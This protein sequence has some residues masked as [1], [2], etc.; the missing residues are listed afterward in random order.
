MAH[1][2][3]TKAVDK[4][5]LPNQP[6]K[7]NFTLRSAYETVMK[8]YQCDHMHVLE[9]CKQWKQGERLK[10][11]HHVAEA[12]RARAATKKE[13]RE[14]EEQSRKHCHLEEEVVEASMSVECCK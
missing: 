3:E 10:D 1:N 11:M 14:V 13:C 2:Y 6:D 8:V 5:L 9:V 4:F 7:G 12:A